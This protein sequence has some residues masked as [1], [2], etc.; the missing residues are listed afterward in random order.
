MS[1]VGRKSTYEA[2]GPN[3]SLSARRTKFFALGT[4]FVAR[5]HLRSRRHV[6]PLE[7]RPGS[8]NV[9]GRR[10]PE[11]LACTLSTPYSWQA[12]ARSSAT[13]ACTLPVEGIFDALA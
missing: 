12:G 6:S 10:Q 11:H 2:T 4:L 13:L 1:R 7:L 5:L 9:L 3:T 8:S